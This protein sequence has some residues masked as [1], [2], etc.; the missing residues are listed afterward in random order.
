MSVRR[1][2]LSLLAAAVLAGG[3]YAVFA[4]SRAAHDEPHIVGATVGQAKFAMLSRFLPP[5]SR[6]DGPTTALEAAVF[7][8]GL[9]PAGDFD[10]VTAK[11]D[12]DRRLAETVFIVV[13]PP[14]ASLDPAD[15]MARLYERFLEDDAWSHPGGL[16]AR[17]FA[18]DSPF[19]GDE[20]YFTAPEGREFAARCSKPDPTAKTPNTCL[21]EMRMGDVDVE[22]R[23]AAALLSEWRTLREG[24]RGLIAAARR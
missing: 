12:L 10:D 4:S 17:A 15:R 3:A 6:H 14:D 21:A 8:P 22:I 5:S 24:A 13:R 2:L 20:L 11:T 19:R 18:D 7:F 23:F 9:A 16:I 1:R